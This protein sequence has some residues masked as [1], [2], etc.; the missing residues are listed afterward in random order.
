MMEFDPD[1]PPDATVSFRLCVVKG[2]RP[3]IYFDGPDIYVG[4]EGYSK[5]ITVHG[6]AKDLSGD[7]VEY[8]N[9]DE[10][11]VSVSFIGADRFEAHLNDNI[12]TGAC[13]PH[14]KIHLR[15]SGGDSWSRGTSDF[16][17]LHITEGPPVAKH[18]AER[19]RVPAAP[20]APSGRR[21]LF[22]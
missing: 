19:P 16:W 7:A 8:N 18:P 5:K 10:I 22:D 11:A 20:A 3:R 9:G 21:G 13:Q 2:M 15:L 17:D 1:L 12:V 6:Q 14:T 4:N